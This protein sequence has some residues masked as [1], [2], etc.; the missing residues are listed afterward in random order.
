MRQLQDSA[1][2]RHF[3]NFALQHSYEYEEAAKK[4]VQQPEIADGESE[5]LLLGFA[6]FLLS[7]GSRID[8][9]L[10]DGLSQESL[11]QISALEA[12][13]AER[14]CPIMA[15]ESGPVRIADF[16]VQY[17][18]SRFQNLVVYKA[19]GDNNSVGCDQAEYRL[20]LGL[21]AID[22]QYDQTRFEKEQSI[23]Q[24]IS[25]PSVAEVVAFGFHLRRP[26]VVTRVTAQQANLVNQIRIPVALTSIQSVKI[27]VQVLDGLVE[28]HS[29]GIIHGNLNANSVDIE[30]GN[31]KLRFIARDRS[32]FSNRSNTD[33]LARTSPVK[34][35]IFAAGCLLF[36]LLTGRPMCFE[37]FWRDP[38]ASELHE[39][40]R[41][42]ESEELLRILFRALYN[43]PSKRFPNAKAFRDNLQAWLT[44][45]S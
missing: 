28:C 42:Q 12:L 17:E 8:K 21:V 7:T 32:T 44:G 13:Y 39:K 14:F 15:Q 26:Y 11:Q 36:E 43:D 45:N 34:S 23:L 10:L 33:S 29:N 27:L 31:A 9:T 2:L 35:D 1:D 22:E 6:E 37:S 4:L 30:H 16:E 38:S 19:T 24:R 20:E 18:V 40:Y 5:S 25:H 3:K 41:I